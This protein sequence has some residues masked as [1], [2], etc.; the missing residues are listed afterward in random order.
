[1][2]KGK[3]N[4]HM[5]RFLGTTRRRNWNSVLG[6]KTM[7]NCVCIK[8]RDPFRLL[9]VYEYIQSD[10]IMHVYHKTVHFVRTP[11][12]SQRWG[13]AYAPNDDSGYHFEIEMNAFYHYFRKL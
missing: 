2:Q 3:T 13:L 7:N 10:D 5:A 6:R 12:N 1:M 11:P 9:R 4:G 8:A